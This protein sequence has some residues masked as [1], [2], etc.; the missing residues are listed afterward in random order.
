MF[1]ASGTGHYDV[2]GN[3]W[4]WGED[5]FNGLPGFKPFFLY[6]DYSSPFFDGRHSMMMVH[7]VGYNSICTISTCISALDHTTPSL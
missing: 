3:L 2:Y 4:E 1:E 5:H 7:G 6:T